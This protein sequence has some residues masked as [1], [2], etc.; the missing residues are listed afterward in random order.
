VAHNGIAK[1]QHYVPQF[2]LRN[3]GT[4]KKDQLH[5]LNKATGKTFL[6]NARN[7]AAE[8]R[9]YDFKIDGADHTIEP[10]LSRVEAAAKPVIQKLAESDSL[11]VLTSEDRE[12]LTVFF[13][14][15]FVRT[16]AARAAAEDVEVQFRELLRSRFCADDAQIAEAGFGSDENIR[17]AFAAKRIIDAPMQF[18]RAFMEKDWVLLSAPAKDPFI[19]GDHPLTLQNAARREG[20]FGNIG[21]MVPGIEIYFPLSPVR[22]LAMWC[23]S[24]GNQIREAAAQ[25]QRLRGLSPHLLEQQIRDPEALLRLAHALET[26]SVLHYQREHIENFNWLQIVYAESFIFSSRDDFELAR[27]VLSQSDELRRGRRMQVG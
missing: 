24:T 4:G 26:G 27:K 10:A 8:S 7:V 13:A 25:M 23:P 2:L 22:A 18:G 16:K 17:A 21:L 5:V 1:V 11:A 15:Q 9:F 12:L 19:I 6:T 14:I 3:F 20:P